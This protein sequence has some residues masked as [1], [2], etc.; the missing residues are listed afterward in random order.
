V[1]SSGRSYVSMKSKVSDRHIVVERDERKKKYRNASFSVGS[2]LENDC[3]S[4]KC[5]CWL[6]DTNSG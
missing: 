5:F 4:Y 3:L 1:S 6:W 2:V